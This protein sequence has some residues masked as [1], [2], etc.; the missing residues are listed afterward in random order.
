MELAMRSVVVA[1]VLVLL[2]PSAGLAQSSEEQGLAIAVEAKRRDTGFGDSSAEL[3]M[4]LRGL[5]GDETTRELR[6]LVLER[7]DDGDRSLVIFDSPRD[8]RGTAM[9]T[10]SNRTG[11]DDQWLYLPALKRVRRITA[12]NKS[13]PFMGSEFAYEDFASQEVEKFT[14]RWLRDEACPGEGDDPLV[15]DV[16]E[17]HPVDVNSGYS[18]QVV[19][20]DQSE[21]RTL[22][23]EYYDRRESLLKTLMLTQY[24]QYLGR[25]WRPGDMLMTNHQTG[26]STRLVWTRYEFRVGLREGDFTA[27][28]LTRVR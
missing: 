9:L 11:D 3:L 23:I 12:A 16:V 4:V 13:G 5:R 21:Y 8:V 27:Q 22:K 10:H 15:C 6:S 24:D 7:V 17:R 25:F 26:R 1:A 14:Y 2:G 28:G 20:I 18:R 19:W